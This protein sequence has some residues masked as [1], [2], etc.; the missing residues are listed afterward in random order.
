MRKL[1]WF[2]LGLLGVALAQDA[3]VGVKVAGGWVRF[4]ARPDMTAAFL[5]LENQSE[6]PFRLV[7]VKSEVAERVEVHETFQEM[8]DGK[9]VM[10]MRP[11]ASLEVP[12]GG[13]LELRPGGYHLM[14][15]GLKR[16]LQ[17]GEKVKLV[18]VFQGG[19]RL[20]VDLPVEMR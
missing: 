12:P 2:L 7:G 5:A 14:L 11:V 17:V 8:R 16:P 13:R 20:P 15:I 9:M 19:L 1:G 10:G 18:L 3:L 6:K 4:P